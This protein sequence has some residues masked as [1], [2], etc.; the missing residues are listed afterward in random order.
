MTGYGNLSI[1]QQ[2]KE[3]IKSTPKN[4]QKRPKGR[5]MKTYQNKI[6]QLKRKYR[7]LLKA[8]KKHNTAFRLDYPTVESYLKQYELKKPNIDK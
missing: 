8:S 4:R 3:T 5:S 7:N 2:S 1:Y 6:N